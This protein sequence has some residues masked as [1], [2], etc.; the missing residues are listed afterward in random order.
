MGRDMVHPA[1]GY[2]GHPPGG[3]AA[4][5]ERPC[6]GRAAR[7]LSPF[8]DHRH[9]RQRRADTVGGLASLVAGGVGPG[10]Q[11]MHPTFG[12]YGEQWTEPVELGSDALLEAVSTV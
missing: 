3:C 4:A 5:S 11:A 2:R 12:K 10:L 7:F 8:D 6:A 1:P 9:Q